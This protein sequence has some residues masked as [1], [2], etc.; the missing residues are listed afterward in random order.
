MG[1][2]KK[3]KN[4]EKKLKYRPQSQNSPPKK[5]ETKPKKT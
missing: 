1:K 2:S 4:S 5:M 3:K